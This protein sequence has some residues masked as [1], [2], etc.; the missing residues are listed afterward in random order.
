MVYIH[1]S[2]KRWEQQIVYNSFI[3]T[4]GLPIHPTQNPSHLTKKRFIE[5][6]NRLEPLGFCWGK[7]S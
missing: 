6:I 3:L 1:S 7:G 5:N 2:L 4:T